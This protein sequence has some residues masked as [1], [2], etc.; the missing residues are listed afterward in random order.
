MRLLL[1]AHLNI[2]ILFSSSLQAQN[3][4]NRIRNV[5]VADTN[6]V[7]LKFPWA[8]GLNN[9]Q[10]S[11]VDLNND[12]IKDLVVFNRANIINADK[13]L[14]FINKGVSGQIDYEYAPEYQTNFP[15]TETDSPRVEYWMLMADYNCDGVEDIFSCTPGYIQL[16]EGSYD[17]NNK[18]KFQYKTF[19]QFNSFTGPLNIFVSSID[20]PAIVDVNGD[21]DIDVL[22]FNIFGYVLEYYENQSMELSGTCGDSLIYAL[23]DDCWGNIYET[24]LNACSE[25][26]DTCGTLIDPLQLQHGNQRHSGSTVCAFD[27]DKDGDMEVLLGD[28]SFTNMNLFFN[29]GRSDSAAMTIPDCFFPSYNIGINMNIF[30]SVFYIDVNNDGRKDLIASPNSPKKSENYNCSWLY[31][32]I[33]AT[34]FDTFQLINHAFLVNDMI[35]VGEG[36]FPVFTD[37]NQ[38]GLMDFMIGNHGYYVN[39]IN[40]K[41]GLALYQNVGTLQNPSFRL[42]SRDGYNLSVLGLNSMSIALGDMDNDGDIDMFIGEEDGEINYFTNIAGAGNPFN[43]TLTE[44]S[45]KAIDVGQ[46]SVPVIYDVDGDGLNDLVIGERSGNLNYYRNIGS[47]TSANSFFGNV[48]VR[49]GGNITG[50]SAPFFSTLDSTGKIY[51]LVGSEADGVKVYD[52]NRD[53]INAGSFTKLF[54]RYSGIHEGERNNPALADINNDG[55]LEML[56]GNY[57]GGVSLF[58]QSDSIILPSAVSKFIDERSFLIYPNPAG[59]ELYVRLKFN[60]YGN[61]KIYVFN[62]LGEEVYRKELFF[63]ESGATINV[64]TDKWGNGIYFLRIDAPGYTGIEKIFVK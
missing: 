52:F 45:Y 32:N 34:N 12:G 63:A 14:T 56:I 49:Y 41:N 30:P 23:V 20:I 54:N 59:E 55:K 19:L 6:G 10:F 17:N 51:L 3:L 64:K 33:S 26:K 31:E 13:L 35:D 47:D 43:F 57:R 62:I 60:F 8:G 5:S 37:F 21:G 38:D 4:F 18:I 50:H 36:S 27:I 2:L 15:V 1:L 42:I 22:T 39:G 48:D 24:G 53:S 46:F 28:I 44:S 40:L 7:L 61:C 16:F 25:I 58:S 9:P 11:A 29:V